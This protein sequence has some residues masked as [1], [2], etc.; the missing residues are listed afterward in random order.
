MA[1]G[2]GRAGPPGAVP[3]REAG[4]RRFVAR[5]AAPRPAVFRAVRRVPAFR[6]VTFLFRVPRARE[7]LARDAF[8]AGAFPARFAVFFARADRRIFFAFAMAE[9]DLSSSGSCSCHA[10]ASGAAPVLP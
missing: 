9:S 6:A 5:R 1:N 8:R 2:A 7:A 3:T 4:E 10:R